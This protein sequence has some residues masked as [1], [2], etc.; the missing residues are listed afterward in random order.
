M[1]IPVNPRL[2]RTTA[3]RVRVAR[4]NGWGAR[5][6]GEKWVECEPNEDDLDL[7]RA[8]VYIA[9]GL[10]MGPGGARLRLASVE[11]LHRRWDQLRG[12]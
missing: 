5:W 6:D 4:E 12:C 2:P 8:D 3:N 9:T 1:P 11:R 7:N 10:D